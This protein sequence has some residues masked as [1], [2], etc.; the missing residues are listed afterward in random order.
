MSSL[1]ASTSQHEPS[2]SS[3]A[4]S[5]AFLSS[6]AAHFHPLRKAAGRELPVHLM[7]PLRQIQYSCEQVL[8]KAKRTHAVFLS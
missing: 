8:R 2:P 6:Q 3:S 4:K 1:P 5:L 7:S